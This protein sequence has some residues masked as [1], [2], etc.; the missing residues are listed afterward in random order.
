[1]V[2]LSR[3]GENED[4]DISTTCRRVKVTYEEPEA[5]GSGHLPTTRVL[6]LFNVALFLDELPEFARD[7]L[8]VLR[9]P[10]ED[11]WC[12]SQGS[13]RLI[14]TRPISAS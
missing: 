10:L 13:T 3:L 5:F 2:T 9:Q 1:M 6:D 4:G 8:E 12:M 14:P 11:G 7:A